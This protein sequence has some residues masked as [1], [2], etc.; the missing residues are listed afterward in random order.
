MIYILGNLKTNKLVANI[1]IYKIPRVPMAD[2]LHG[3]II[4]LSQRQVLVKHSFPWYCSCG[5]K[6]PLFNPP[7]I[8]FGKVESYI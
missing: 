2:R 1:C 3:L 6:C 5:A 4:D 8:K 7:Y